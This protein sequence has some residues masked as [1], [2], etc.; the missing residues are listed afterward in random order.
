MDPVP[1][2]I[3]HYKLYVTSDGS[4]SPVET[5]YFVTVSAE[6][7]AKEKEQKALPP[8]LSDHAIGE[9]IAREK[10]SE[11]FRTQTGVKSW[12]FTSSPFARPA[13]SA[14]R[15]EGDGVVVREQIQAM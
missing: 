1:T 11:V 15:Y 7:I 9:A 14:L 6:C 13:L 4:K 3:F 10:C 5:T 8:D 12:R 2:A